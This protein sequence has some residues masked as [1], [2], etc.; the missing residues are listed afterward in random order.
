MPTRL[1]QKTQITLET[2]FGDRRTIVFGFQKSAFPTFHFVLVYLVELAFKSRTTK[3]PA[4]GL[5]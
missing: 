4:S 1:T 5:G 3:I 2:L